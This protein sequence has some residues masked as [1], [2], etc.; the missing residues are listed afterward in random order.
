MKK[1]T[2]KDIAKAAGVSI[3]TVSYILNDVKT[4]SISDET[5]MKVLKIA[6]QLHY[7]TNRSARSLKLQKTGLI[8]I[9]LFRDL[10]SQPWSDLKYV[11]TLYTLE[12]LCG[13]LGYHVIFMQ[14][15]GDAPSYDMIRERNLDGVFLIN[16]DQERFSTVSRFFGFGIPVFVI[17]S[18]IE[19]TL[20]HKVLPDF[21]SSFRIAGTLLG[22]APDF[23]VMDAYNNAEFVDTIK[24]LSGLDEERIHRYESKEGLDDFLNKFTDRKGLVINEFLANEIVRTRG[25]QDRI[26]VLC[27]SHCPD[28]LP[29][30]VV[31]LSYE[32]N[33]YKPVVGMM[34][35]NIQDA[36]YSNHNKFIYLSV[37]S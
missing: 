33:D 13:E 22:S 17:D 32:L 5:R 24:Q 20:F 23:L 37:T 8:G 19:D 3:A 6:Q 7:V 25:T 10:V 9:L 30:H 18:W 34:N 28:I 16:V 29:A 27:T 4:Q 15:D 1:A 12:R 35:G 11:K 2:I 36:D 21:E 26:A 14:V 31:N